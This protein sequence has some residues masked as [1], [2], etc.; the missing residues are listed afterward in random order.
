MSPSLLNK[1]I[2][3]MLLVLVFCAAQG[4]SGILDDAFTVAFDK[5]FSETRGLFAALKDDSSIAEKFEQWMAKHGRSYNSITE[6][7]NRFYIFKDNYEY[8]E[9]FNKA[10]NK[11]FKLGI[12]AFSDLTN[13]EFLAMYAG[14]NLNIPAISSPLNTTSRYQNR[15][16]LADV[17]SSINWVEKGAVTPIKNQ[18]SCGSC[19]TFSVIAATEGIV[20]IKTGE[21]LTLSEQQILDCNFEYYGC[22]GGSII[23]A[24]DYIVRNK[25]I[26]NGTTYPYEGKKLTCNTALASEI[27]A[28]ISN[29]EILHANDEGA[30]LE[31][32][33]QQPVSVVID[34]RGRTFQHYHSGVYTAPCGTLPNHAITAVGYG[35]SE[36]GIKY[37]LL[38]NSWATTWGEDGYMRIKRDDSNSYGHCGIAMHSIYPVF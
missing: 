2:A 19:W 18:G 29:F 17:P 3:S 21:L 36:D 6:R 32:V 26:A 27:T 15:R 20:Q 34:T 13:D 28:Q 33:A 5:V 22:H 38:K 7:V 4:Q 30:L 8:I 24:Y 31:A 11:T 9:N 10:K 16:S 37:W 12:N 25:G 14:S 35:T 1:S 23:A